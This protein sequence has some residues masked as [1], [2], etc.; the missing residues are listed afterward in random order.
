MEIVKIVLDS[1][2]HKKIQK[3]PLSNYVI[4]SLVEDI[5]QYILLQVGQILKPVLW[6]L[7]AQ[8]DKSTD[9]DNCNQLLIF[10]WYIKEREILE[11]LLFCEH[12]GLMAKRSDV[13]N[14]IKGLCVCVCF[15][16]ETSN[17]NRCN[18]LNL[19]WWCP[20]DVRQ[21]LWIF[22]I[23]EETSTASYNKTLH[24]APPCTCIKTLPEKLKQHI[25][26]AVNVVNYL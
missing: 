7:S 24:A 18:R 4:W 16:F 15:F 25:A 22:C 20:C 9:V 11:E 23:Y 3:I 19:H 13:F 14:L 21:K 8:L 26:I 1:E 5:S 10:V 2:A 6:K 17:T 12:L